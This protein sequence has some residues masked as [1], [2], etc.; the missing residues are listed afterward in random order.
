MESTGQD[1]DDDQSDKGDLTDDDYEP[2]S[3]TT[4]T[5]ESSPLKLKAGFTLAPQTPPIGGSTSK[6]KQA[7]LEQQV[8]LL[9]KIDEQNEK[10]KLN[11]QKAIDVAIDI[12]LEDQRGTGS[13][14]AKKK[15]QQQS[16]SLISKDSL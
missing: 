10:G 9:R 13:T 11:A 12:S 14:T 6:E 5:G 8:V 16:N 15:K 2:E 3:E 1:N 4:S 7:L